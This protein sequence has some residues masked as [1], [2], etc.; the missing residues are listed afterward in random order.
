MK[1]LILTSLFV[2]AILLAGC[3]RPWSI[4][5][6]EDTPTPEALTADTANEGPSAKIALAPTNRTNTPAFFVKF[7]QDVG[8][9]LVWLDM[10]EPN[11][12]FQPGV[13]P[14]FLNAQE[15]ELLVVIND[16]TKAYECG[17]GPDGSGTTADVA[18]D[19]S[20][21][22]ANVKEMQAQENNVAS[23]FDIEDGMV[24]NIYQQCLP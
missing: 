5:V 3:T 23:Y 8:N 11:P 20:T 15:E 7:G 21:Y 10:L 13:T 4:K 22:L 2:A 6:V 19:V 16:D 18:I 17:A 9:V 14:F 12:D 24:K 1:N